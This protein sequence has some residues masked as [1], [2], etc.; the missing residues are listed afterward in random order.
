MA[1]LARCIGELSG[2][3]PERACCQFPVPLLVA[4]MA[5]KAIR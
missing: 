3:P 4:E 2:D 5:L 1:P